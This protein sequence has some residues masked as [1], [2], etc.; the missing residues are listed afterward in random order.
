[1]AAAISAGPLDG[2][3]SPHPSL[4]GCVCCLFC[5]LPSLGDACAD[6]RCLFVGQC[7]VQNY[8]APAPVWGRTIGTITVIVLDAPA[9]SAGAVSFHDW[10]V[11]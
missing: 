7:V 10:T 5:P 11:V 6:L 8:S 9:R 1:M 4:W 2:L 3:Y